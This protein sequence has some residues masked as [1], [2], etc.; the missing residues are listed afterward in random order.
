MMIGGHFSPDHTI[1]SN[2][3]YF[4]INGGY[5][6]LGELQQPLEGACFVKVN[7]NVA[8]A[9]GGKTNQNGAVTGDTYLFDIVNRSWNFDL[10]KLQMA[11]S[12]GACGIVKDTMD[13]NVEYAII[14]AGLIFNPVEFFDTT[15]VLHVI[16][17][18]VQGGWNYGPPFPAKLAFSASAQ[19]P[20]GRSFFVSGGSTSWDDNINNAKNDIFRFRCSGGYCSWGLMPQ[21]LPSPRFNHVMVAVPADRY[22]CEPENQTK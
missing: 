1:L 20:D 15:E 8:L 14:A 17:G 11:R 12:F 4:N 22:P 2:V 16:N 19:A 6:A 18:E 10:P 21:K 5:E 9:Y 7:E 3:N 13:D